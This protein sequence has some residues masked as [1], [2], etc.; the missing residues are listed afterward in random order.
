MRVEIAHN[1]H[2][3]FD[4]LVTVVRIDEEGRRHEFGAHKIPATESFAGIGMF[5]KPLAVVRQALQDD[6]LE[7]VKQVAPQ[8]SAPA[9]DTPHP[10]DPG[11]DGCPQQPSGG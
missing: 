6:I 5:N 9:S 11:I 4:T 7:A 3:D 8:S 10:K 1:G 2:C